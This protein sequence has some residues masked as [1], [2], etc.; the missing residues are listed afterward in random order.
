MKKL[1]FSILIITTL[2]ILFFIS[3]ASSQNKLQLDPESEDFLSKV[4][5]IIA[6][7]ESKIFSELPP[8]ARSNFIEEFWK[9]RDPTPQTL[10]NEYREA[11]FERIVDAN[12]LFKG[13][14]SGW[15]QDR[16][17]LYVLFGPPNERVTNPMGGRPIDPFADAR[18]MTSGQ[19]VATGEKPTE[20]W[21]YYNLFS[22]FSQPH[23]VEIVFVDSDGTGDYRLSTNIDEAIPGGID[24]LLKPDLV[25][26]HE[27]HKE[28]AERAR[29]FLQ[30]ALFDFSWVFIKQ[31]N[32]E[33]PSNLLLE[34]VCPYKK[35]IF[36]AEEGNLR[37]RMEL[38]IRITDASKRVVWEHEKGYDLDFAERFVEVNEGGEWKVE[39]PVASWLERGEYSVYIS[40]KNPLG[41]QFIE[42]LLPLKM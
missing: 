2:Q 35:I 27:L 9:R 31:K 37:A 24:A 23:S 19:R 4:R 25:F 39:V 10:S 30:R 7:E 20:V 3:C 5:Y 41:D 12:R 33:L 32:K 38:S 17:R 8:E 22:S 26:A 18:E 15:L 11:Y 1:A 34:L 40:L 14:R 29:L 42:K 28:E 13:P 21:I 16:G 6:K 36:K